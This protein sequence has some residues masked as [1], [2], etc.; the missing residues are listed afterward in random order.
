MANKSYEILDHP[1]DV[2]VRVFGDTKEELF[3][4]AMRGMNEVLKSVS[5]KKAVN[6]RVVVNSFDL[7]ALLVDFLSEV[8]YLSQVNKE[9]YTDIKFNKFS[10]KELEGELI[11]NTIE[12]FAEDI[13]AVTY[14]DLKIEKKDGLYEATILFDI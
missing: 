9:I 8:L 2:R 3:S 1:S 13:K 14:H 10:D 12:S 6:Q 4:N 11:G 7:N 5:L